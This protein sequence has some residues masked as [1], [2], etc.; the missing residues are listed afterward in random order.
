MRKK[1]RVKRKNL[2]LLF[3]TIHKLCLVHSPLLVA[4][5]VDAEADHAQVDQDEDPS[6]DVGHNL[7]GETVELHS[8][9]LGHIDTLTI[10]TFLEHSKWQTDLLKT[11]DRSISDNHTEVFL[12]IIQK[13]F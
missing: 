7:H 4:D 11:L 6:Q 3:N 13:Y 5:D 9:T 10:V 8:F 2:I 12:T 1:R